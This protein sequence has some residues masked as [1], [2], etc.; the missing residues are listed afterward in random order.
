MDASYERLNSF[1]NTFI[2]GDFE[3]A[4]EKV[5][6]NLYLINLNIKELQE[7]LFKIGSKSENKNL[8]A[9]S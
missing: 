3:R 2:K 5:D 6:D 9:K 8:I 4:K 7:Y 1:K